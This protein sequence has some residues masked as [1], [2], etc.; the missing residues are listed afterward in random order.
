M[1]AEGRPVSIANFNYEVKLI[2]LFM[3]PR[4]GPC[5]PTRHIDPGWRAEGPRHLGRPTKRTPLAKTQ[6]IGRPGN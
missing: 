4:W 3:A 5:G 1:K 2:V 6:Q